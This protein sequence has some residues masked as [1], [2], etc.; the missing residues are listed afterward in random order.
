MN[1]IFGPSGN[2]LEF[3]EAGGKATVE[4]PAWLAQYGLDAYEYSAGKGIHAS[5]ATFEKIGEQAKQYNI[6]MS[7]HTPYYIS[8]SGVDPEKRLKSIT[9]IQDSLAAASALGADT[10]VIH[11]GSAAKIS[12]EEALALAKDTLRRTLDAVE[13]TGIHLGIET[14]GKVKQLGTLDEVIE[15]CSLDK[16]LY[17]VVDFGHL[18]AREFG[19]VFQTEDDYKRV[20]DQIG[21]ALGDEKAR[22]LHCHFSKIQYTDPGGEKAHLTFEDTVYGPAFEPL[23]QVIVKEGLCLRIICESAGTQ[24]KDALFMKR[25]VNEAKN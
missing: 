23:G 10:I 21:T 16:R 17:P 18:N 15:L 3:Y 25:Y 11:A 13:D 7:F 24:A 12:R 8:L 14:M 4:M 2:P 1:A 6:K 5:L 19:G 20:F 22:F 9:Y